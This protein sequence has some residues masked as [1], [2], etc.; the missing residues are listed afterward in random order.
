MIDDFHAIEPY[1]LPQ[2]EKEKLLLSEL[3]ALTKH[4]AD[5][6]QTYRN[7][8]SSFGTDID[9]IKEIADIPFL[10]VRIFKE[11]DLKSIPDSDIFKTMTSSGTTGTKRSR[12]FLDKD[13]ALLQQK[14]MLRLLG[15]FIGKKRLPMLVVDTP[16]ILKDR[17]LFT[18]RG[19]TVM[20][21]DFAA[22]KKVF[23]LDSDLNLNKA[24]I[25]DF[26]DE[27]GKESFL[28]FGLT[29]M[30]WKYLYPG[31]E[32]WDEKPDLSQGFLLTGGG[33]K[34]LEHEAVSREDFKKRGESCSGLRRFIDHY[35]MAEQAGSIYLECEYGHLH[36]GIYTDMIPRRFDDFS[37]CEVGE[38]GI[39]EV[40][41]VLPRSY[42]GHA[43][44][45]EDQGYIEGVDDCPC[46]RKG[47]YIKILGR[48]KSA[49]IRGCSDAYTGTSGV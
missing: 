48:V 6:C 4:H 5:H 35:G 44:L 42:P 45:T 7:I 2:S 40:L 28:I 13:N 9:S 33:W 22:R 37:P 30:V 20:G 12:I 15:D 11:R 36:S 18:A 3:K 21:L 49:E 27:Y 46:G 38:T 24:A 34:K 47:K 29:Y 43:I 39:I 10:P 14:V 19:A 17:K 16:D 26:L 31:L 23:V 32:S 1:S 41:S 8:L 25:K